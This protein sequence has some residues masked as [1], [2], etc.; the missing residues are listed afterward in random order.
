MMTLDQAVFIAEGLD[1]AEEDEIIEA[2]QLL[3]DSGLAYQLQGAFGRQAQALLE[4]G[5]IT[6]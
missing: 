6:E 3:H 1:E 5:I 2:W 4:A